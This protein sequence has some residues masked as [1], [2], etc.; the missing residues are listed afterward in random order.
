MRLSGKVAVIT[1]AARGIGR[2]C[3]ER[4]LGDGAKV[5]LADIDSAD[6]AKTAAELDQPAAVR[7]IET[8]VSKV[9]DVERV[10]ALA[11]SAF[12]RQAA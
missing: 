5:V 10:V 1:G 3:A 11:V 6:L 9:S 4:F 8:D 12:G 2:A 7:T